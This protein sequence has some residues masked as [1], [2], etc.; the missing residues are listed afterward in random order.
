MMTNSIPSH[1][2]KWLNHYYRCPKR[3][4]DKDA[5]PQPRNYRADK[6]EPQV[7]GLVSSLMTDPEQLRAD[8]ERMIELERETLRGDPKREARAWRNKLS[9]VEWQRSRAQDM[10]IAGLLCYDELGA[11]LAVLD[12]TRKTAERELEALRNHQEHIEELERDKDALLEFYAGLAPEILAGLTPEER[13]QVYKMLRVRAV[14]HVD[15]TLE[16]SRALAG[17][18]GISNW[19]AAPA[20]P[21][22]TPSAP[23]S[24][25]P[26]P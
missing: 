15:G 18:I 21:V 13:H 5:C 22:T 10:A 16:V 6:T 11:K 26:E 8:L 3:M 9:E 25:I 1:G 4:R 24:R 17:A 20:S 14:V 2:K 7:W 19:G 12:E 23:S